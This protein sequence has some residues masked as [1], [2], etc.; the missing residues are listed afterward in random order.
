MLSVNPWLNPLRRTVNEAKERV[1]RSEQFGCGRLGPGSSGIRTAWICDGDP[2][3]CSLALVGGA[4]EQG[5]TVERLLRLAQ[6]EC[7]PACG[8]SCCLYS[9]LML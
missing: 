2:D 6:V 5:R 4:L 3:W 9:V 8:T 7:Q 1:S